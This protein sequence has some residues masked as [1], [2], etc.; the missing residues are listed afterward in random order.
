MRLQNTLSRIE[1]KKQKADQ[2]IRCRNSVARPSEKVYCHAFFA[3]AL[4]LI[5]LP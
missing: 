5:N 4:E 1:I 3:R 2:G